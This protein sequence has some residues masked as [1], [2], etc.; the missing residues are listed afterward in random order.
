MFIIYIVHV[1]ICMCVCMCVEVRTT[2]CNW[3][4]LSPFMRVPGIELKQATVLT[5]RVPSVAEESHFTTLW[6]MKNFLTLL[7]VWGFIVESVSWK[8]TCYFWLITG[9][10]IVSQLVYHNQLVLFERKDTVNQFCCCYCCNVRLFS[11]PL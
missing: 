4:S 11:L 7:S 6:P 9:K 2:L 1:C 8:L 5:W 3:V 10:I